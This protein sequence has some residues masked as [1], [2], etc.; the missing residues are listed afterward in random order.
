MATLALAMNCSMRSVRMQ[1][2]LVLEK[3]KCVPVPTENHEGKQPNA[4]ILKLKLEFYLRLRTWLINSID[5]ETSQT[6]LE[7]KDDGRPKLPNISV[8]FPPPFVKSD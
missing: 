3:R 6:S 2:L 4:H 8:K 1:V 7:A 5:T